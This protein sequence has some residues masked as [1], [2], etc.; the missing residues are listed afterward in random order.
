MPKTSRWFGLTLI[1]ALFMSLLG[2]TSRPAAAAGLIIDPL[3]TQKLNSVLPTTSLQA[4]LTYDHKPTTL[5]I[6]AVTGLGLL[7][8]KFETLP[9]LGILGTPPQIRAALGLGGLRSAYYNKPLEYLL[10]ESVPLI[11]AD[12]VWNELGYTGRGVGVA[13]IDSGI[14]GLHPDLQFGS[15]VVQ[16]VKILAPN[17]FGLGPIVAEN[18]PTSDTTSGHGTH[19]AGT[20]GGRGTASDG[21]YRGVAPDSKLIGISAGDAISILFALEGFDYALAHRTQYNIRVIS[22]SWGTTGEFV[23]TDPI[24]VASKQAHDAGVVV[25]FAAGNEGPGN[26]TLNPYSVAPWVIGVAAGAKDGATLGDFSSRG[27]PGDSLYHPT[28][29]APGVSIVSTRAPNSILPVLGAPDDLSI[30]PAWIP[31]YTTMSGT[32]MAT[33]HVAGVLALMLEAKP[34]LTP[35]QL[36]DILVQTAKPM[37]GYQQFEVG[38]GY[39]DAY[40]ATT[41]ARSR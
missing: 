20:I 3:L 4:I 16:N 39:I 8:Q 35:D 36:K 37:P 1:V 41:A 13:V 5:D 28:I 19:V 11:G 34:T 27:I 10:H 32:S 12:R 40:A 17:L 21:Y 22:N 7:V 25:V 29:T 33:P 38:A 30:N 18:L 15:A 14:D 2:P 26:N 6:A 9:M 24:N 31:Y 23:A